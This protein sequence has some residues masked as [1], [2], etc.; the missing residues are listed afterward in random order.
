MKNFQVISGAVNSVF[1]VYEV[2]DEVFESLFPKGTDVAFVSD[3]DSDD[4]DFWN[5]VY[6]R[7]VDKKSV[8]GI[9]GTLHVTGSHVE[10]EF[11]L[12]RRETDVRTPRY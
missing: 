8:C 12:S 11:F 10:K 2:S 9:H 5:E 1:E 6:R 4:V 7:Q 3:F